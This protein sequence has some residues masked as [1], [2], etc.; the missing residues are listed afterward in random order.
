V[1]ALHAYDTPAIVTL[2]VESIDPDYHGWIVE[3][4]GAGL[5]T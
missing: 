4:T 5:Q 2:P 3:E 1:K